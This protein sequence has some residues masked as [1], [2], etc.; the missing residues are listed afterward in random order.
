[1]ERARVQEIACDIL[2]KLNIPFTLKKEQLDCMLELVNKNDVLG[3]LPTG[4]GKSLVY[5]LFPHLLD[6]IHNRPAGYHVII[7]AS[8]LKSLMSDQVDKFTSFGLS[9]VVLNSSSRENECKLIHF[10]MQIMQ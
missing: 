6:Y 9:S 5:C 2:L 4:Y 7:I 10:F 3:I 8:P 1:M